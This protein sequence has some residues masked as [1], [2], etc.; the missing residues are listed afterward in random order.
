MALEVYYKA[1]QLAAIGGTDYTAGLGP[2]GSLNTAA[3]EFK[4][5]NEFEV[6][7]AHLVIDKNNAVAAGAT[8]S[9]DIQTLMS[10][11][12]CLKNFDV[13]TLERMNLL[14]DCKLGRS[15]AYPQ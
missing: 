9:S 5:M 1:K 7:L 12:K 3:V 15:K 8:I 2:D 4:T 6:E 10:E 14:L 11:I 13:P